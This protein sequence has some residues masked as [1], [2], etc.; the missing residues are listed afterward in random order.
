MKN[1]ITS[2]FIIISTCCTSLGQTPTYSAKM[3]TFGSSG[4]RFGKFAF[5]PDTV[6]ISRFQTI[7]HTSD[8]NPIRS[9]N[10]NNVYFCIG[11]SANIPVGPTV[12]HKL[13]IR[14]GYSP[15]QAFNCLPKV[16]TFLSDLQMVYYQDSINLGDL[17]DPKIR[18]TWLKFPLNKGNF[19]LD[20][21][22]NFVIEVADGPQNSEQPMELTGSQV[23]DCR[24]LIGVASIPTAKTGQR[25]LLNFGFDID[26][27]GVEGIKNIQSF[28]LFP[29]PSSGS[30]QMSFDAAKPVQMA[31]I[32]VT[33]GNGQVV[34]MKNMQ[35]LG[36]HFFRAIDL[37][38]LPKGTYYL[39]LRADADI[40]HQKLIL[41]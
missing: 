39:E 13:T 3:S 30:F 35:Q 4:I 17:S 33:N 21:S 37:S 34:Y 1:I 38:S 31:E 22:R 41:K 7:Y 19:Y 18:G 11:P 12:Y 36:T 20:T 29:N 10:I 8:F 2:F 32:M 16:D 5:P 27:T 24:I 9:G 28:G 15:K 25:T 14:M 40:L 23:L 26:V 6:E